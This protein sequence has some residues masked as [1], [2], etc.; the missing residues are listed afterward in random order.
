M[1]QQYALLPAGIGITEDVGALRRAALVR[2]RLIVRVHLQRH[3]AP[4][5]TGM[6][7]VV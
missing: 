3:V 2:R 6:E 7:L 4:V 1:I 5:N